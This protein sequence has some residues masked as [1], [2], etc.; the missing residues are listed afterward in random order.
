MLIYSFAIA[1]VDG[2]IEYKY[3]IANHGA[4]SAA[5]HRHFYGL[6]KLFLLEVQGGK[7]LQCLAETYCNVYYRLIIVCLPHIMN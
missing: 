4:S 7:N 6:L 1:M 3:P 5:F 2:T